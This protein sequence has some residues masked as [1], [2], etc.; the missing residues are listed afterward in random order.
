[1]LKR[2]GGMLGCC[3]LF[4]QD[5]DLQIGGPL[6]EDGDLTQ[7]LSERTPSFIDLMATKSGYA[8]KSSRH[9]Q[10]HCAAWGT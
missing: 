6:L 4:G 5:L 3:L 10:P 1:M 7:K 2:L 8:L 9:L